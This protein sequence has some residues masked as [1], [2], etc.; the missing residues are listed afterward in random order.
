M[1]AAMTINGMQHWCWLL[2]LEESSR[3]YRESAGD[4]LLSIAL[5]LSGR[6]LAA[7]GVADHIGATQ[8]HCHHHHKQVVCSPAAQQITQ[9]TGRIHPHMIAR[10]FS[11]G[12][13]V[14]PRAWG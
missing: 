1:A 5:Q 2:L 7:L 11:Q 13:M 4:S 3:L 12:S 10:K 8:H 9:G 6:L 14:E